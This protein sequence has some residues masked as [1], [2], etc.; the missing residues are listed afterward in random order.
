MSVVT[1]AL[2]DIAA[3]E[4]Q[5]WGTLWVRRVM[6]DLCLGPTSTMG[7]E[8]HVMGNAVTLFV[9]TGQ[10]PHGAWTLEGVPLIAP[11]LEI[12]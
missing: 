2:W 6:G 3:N 9:E 10:E 8:E 5:G 1:I 11:A 4:L 7:L 12:L